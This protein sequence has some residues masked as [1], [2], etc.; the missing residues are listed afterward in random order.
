M[1][2]QSII[3]PNIKFFW[4]NQHYLISITHW[5][6][7]SRQVIT[8]YLLNYIIM[9]KKLSKSI[10]SQFAFLSSMTLNSNPTRV[11]NIFHEIFRTCVYI[12][13]FLPYINL[14]K[15]AA[16]WKKYPFCYFGR[17]NENIIFYDTN[18]IIFVSTKN[19]DIWPSYAV[20][21]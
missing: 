4:W 6:K 11:F 8:Q 7:Y 5:I 21:G 2:S 10:K 3:W 12:T 13:G 16:K 9:S 18:Q 14:R 19:I 17:E 15:M 1:P 20:M